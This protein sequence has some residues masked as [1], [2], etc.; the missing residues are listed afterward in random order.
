M[1]LANLALVRAQVSFQVILHRP[2]IDPSPRYIVCITTETEN[3][4]SLWQRGLQSKRK[5]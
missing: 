4:R 1:N 5:V 2:E 3:E